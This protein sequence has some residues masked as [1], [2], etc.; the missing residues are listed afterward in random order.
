MQQKTALILSVIKL[1]QFHCPSTG[2]TAWLPHFVDCG[3][4]KA[5][6]KAAIPVTEVSDYTQFQK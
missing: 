1:T 4:A 5:L 3:T 6:E 2:P